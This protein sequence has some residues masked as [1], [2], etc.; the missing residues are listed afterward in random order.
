MK[1]LA[2]GILAV[3]A[4]A[5]LALTQSSFRAD[6]HNVTRWGYLQSTGTF[7]D[8]T[9]KVEDDSAHPA[10]GTY[11]CLSSANI[12]TGD[13]ANMPTDPNQLTNREAGNFRLNP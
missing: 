2:F 12:C 11:S 10:H 7:V 13:D 6:N 8:I 3:V 9:G 4:G 1:K 5:G